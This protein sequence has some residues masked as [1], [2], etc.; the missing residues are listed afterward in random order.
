[1]NIEFDLEIHTVDS[2]MKALYQNGNSVSA[3]FNKNNNKLIV[4]IAF[5]G[6]PSDQEKNQILLKINNDAIDYELREKIKK[7]TESI[8][9]L[10]LAHAFSKTVFIEK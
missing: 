10:M 2:V 9:N 3:K 8:R 1:M 6:N 4:E 5:I 7:E